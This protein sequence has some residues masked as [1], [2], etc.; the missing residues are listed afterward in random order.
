MNAIT[1][2]KLIYILSDS[3]LSEAEKNAAAEVFLADQNDGGAE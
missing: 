2:N 1:L 3:Q